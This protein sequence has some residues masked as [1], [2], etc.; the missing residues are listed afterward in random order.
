MNDLRKQ[1]RNTRILVVDDNPADLDFVTQILINQ[2][3]TVQSAL[4]G[5]LAL[6]AV[7]SM[8]PNLIL[9]DI[10]LPGMDGYEVCEKL[11]LSEKTRDVP[12]I[13]LSAADQVLDK[14]KAFSAGGVDFISKPYQ[15]EEVFARIALHLSLRGLQQELEVRVEERT[16]DLSKANA[17]LQDEI[18]A[19]KQVEE[20]LRGHRDQL[21]E[22]INA[23]K[24]AEEE[25]RMHRDHLE[26]LVKERTAELMAAKENKKR[27]ALASKIIGHSVSIENVRK[28]IQTVAHTNAPVLI[29]GETGT[30]K[31]MVA[32]SL[33]EHSP[34]ADKPFVALN[35]AALPETIFESEMFGAEAGAYTSAMKRRI[36][37]MEHADGGTLFLD[38]IE[39]MPLTLQAKLLRVLQEGV[40]ERLGGNESIR[41]DVR[42][43]AA[44]KG[45]LLALSNQG[46]FR[47]D[48]YYRL[49]VVIIDLPSLRDRREDIPMLFEHFALEAAVHY[50]RPAPMLS[51]TQLTELMAYDW[52]GNVRELHNAADRFVLGVLNEHVGIHGATPAPKDLLQQVE[53]F[54]RIV[55]EAELR[56]NGGVMNRAAKALGIARNTLFYKMKKYKLFSDELGQEPPG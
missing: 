56:Q 42:I 44:V 54:E 9:L 6:W 8:V 23:R 20:Q 24:R 13:F 7:Q 29:V 37:K 18:E 1:E 15:A 21:Q 33:H 40:I 34:R 50:G 35:C 28:R 38:E 26:E 5:Q 2:G 27:Q 45:D 39:S 16:A 41:I 4:D 3:Y 11:K 10:N 25:L 12:V 43:V 53:D 51:Q 22:E 17:H 52:P 30:G 49:N 32:R 47:N 19:R 14:V 48:L 46:K 31:E 36:G 55:I